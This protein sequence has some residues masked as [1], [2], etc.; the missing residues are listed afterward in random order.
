MEAIFLHGLGQTPTS[1]RVVTK[2]LGIQATCPDL[3]VL[4]SEKSLTYGRLYRAFTEVCNATVGQIDLCGLSL[5]GVLALHYA[6]EH[7]DKVH[8]LVLIAAQYRMPRGTLRLQ[9]ILFR[10]M[11]KEIF[12]QTGFSRE[13]MI[14]LCASMTQLDL[15]GSLSGISC[16]V[17]VVC[18]EEDAANLKASKELAARI[19]SSRL[20]IV[21]GAGHEVNLNAP[22][23][24]A[25][26]LQAF[27]QTAR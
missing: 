9:N 14:S 12:A 22:E 27:Y 17:L 3:S 13:N 26:L 20:E 25:D 7:P 10:L 1:W 15:S 5:G 24:L 18:G 4:S 11:P 23:K 2:K 8:S 16:P 19:P 21:P 6:L